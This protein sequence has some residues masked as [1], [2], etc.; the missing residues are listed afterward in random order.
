MERKRGG[1]GMGGEGMKGTGAYT[2]WTVMPCLLFTP[3]QQY[4]MH[5]LLL[6]SNAPAHSLFLSPCDLCI[7]DLSNCCYRIL[8]KGNLSKEGLNLS[9][10]LEGQSIRVE[11]SHQ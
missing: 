6:R 3:S 7:S 2:T 9:H 4:H 11:K 8:D 1:E 5:C 10:T